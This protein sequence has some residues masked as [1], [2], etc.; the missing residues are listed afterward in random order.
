M[1]T[2]IPHLGIITKDAEFDWYRSKPVRVKV[3]GGRECC[4][5]V[6]EYD[7]DDDRDQIHDTI[8]NF[9]SI[10]QAVLKEVEPELMAYYEDIF[11]AVGNAEP[12]FP[13][14][15]SPDDI[16]EHIRFGNEPIVSRRPY[17]DHGIYVSV[18]CECDWEPE[19]GLQIVFKSGRVVN[20]VGP[21]DGHLSNA[22][23]YA[24]P[25]LEDV[26]YRTIW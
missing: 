5:V 15:S 26:V 13:R 20:K 16:W 23:A 12:D 1:S 11:R 6:E 24:D 4:I 21:Y 10:D 18:E 14:I 19:H 9:L 3:L 22:D 7:Q 17:G 8:S 2:E 25:K